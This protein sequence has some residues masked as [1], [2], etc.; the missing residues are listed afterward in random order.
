MVSNAYYK[1]GQHVYFLLRRPK[2]PPVAKRLPPEHSSSARQRKDKEIEVYFL[3]FLRLLLFFLVAKIAK[4][5]RE[6][7]HIG[8]RRKASPGGDEPLSAQAKNT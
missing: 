7:S 4:P 8:T 2:L 5:S 3:R 1:T 6:R